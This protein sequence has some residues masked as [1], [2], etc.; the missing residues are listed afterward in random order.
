LASA[1]GSFAGAMEK[2]WESGW[3]LR[4]LQGAK[5]LSTALPIAAVFLDMFKPEDPAIAAI[6]KKIDELSAKMD[7]FQ[8][9]NR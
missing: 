6:S 4:L 2:V 5:I 8:D 1:L 3:G 9:E 7:K